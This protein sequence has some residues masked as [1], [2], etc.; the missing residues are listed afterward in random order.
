MAQ[1]AI[2]TWIVSTIGESFLSFFF[3]F[4]QMLK[5]IEEQQF[6]LLLAQ[7]VP[8]FK[9]EYM[10]GFISVVKPTRCTNVTYLFY[11]GMAFYMFRTVFPSI[12]RSSRL[13]IQQ[14]NRYCCLLASG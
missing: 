7:G 14:P 2:P 13:Y 6:Q 10:R 9:Y 11:F 8:A 12:I 4:S 5:V 3:L 1:A